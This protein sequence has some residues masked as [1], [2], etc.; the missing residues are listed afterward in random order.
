MARWQENGEKFIVGRMG[1][2]DDGEVGEIFGAGYSSLESFSRT[3]IN[4]TLDGAS[5]F[6]EVFGGRLRCLVRRIRTFRLADAF[7][8]RVF[9]FLFHAVYVECLAWRMQS[10]AT[11]GYLVLSSHR[12]YS[13][14]A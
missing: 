9:G 11:G 8:H 7:G 4:R 10:A 2:W 1:K 14:W 3:Q 12:L 6:H 5:E 13:A